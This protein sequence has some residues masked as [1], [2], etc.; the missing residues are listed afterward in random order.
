MRPH[1]N[2]QPNQK[3]HLPPRTAPAAARLLD[4]LGAGA[5]LAVLPNGMALA[6]QADHLV[7]TVRL[8][9]IHGAVR[10]TPRT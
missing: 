4:Y 10:A 9:D 5:L 7:E 1:L 8:A 3:A 6:V 2:Q